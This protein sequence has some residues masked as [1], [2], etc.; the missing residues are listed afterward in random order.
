MLKISI[1]KQFKIVESRAD[2]LGALKDRLANYDQKCGIFSKYRSISRI[3]D[4]EANKVK[5]QIQDNY[6]ANKKKMMSLT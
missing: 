1:S 4:M 6:L 3:E 2:I 5:N